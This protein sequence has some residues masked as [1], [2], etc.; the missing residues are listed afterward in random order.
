VLSLLGANHA[1][2]LGLLSAA[3]QARLGAFLLRMLQLV[4]HPSLLLA[5]FALPF[6]QSFLADPQALQV[7]PARSPAQ[8]CRV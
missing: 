8:V 7:W 1:P 4:A 2:A 6:W 3:H 5:S